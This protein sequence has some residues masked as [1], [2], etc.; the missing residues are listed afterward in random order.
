MKRCWKLA[1]GGRLRFS[2]LVVR[3]DKTLQPV[4]GYVELSMT[5][6]K[7]GPGEEEEEDWTGYEV[8]EPVPYEAGKICCVTYYI[9]ILPFFS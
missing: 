1:P 3:V 9:I 4:A 7:L 8:M 6:E 2:D 5:L